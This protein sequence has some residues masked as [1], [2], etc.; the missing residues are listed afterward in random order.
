MALTY[1]PQKYRE[2][3]VRRAILIDMYSVQREMFSMFDRIT[4]RPNAP[5]FFQRGISTGQMTI[6]DLQLL[7]RNKRVEKQYEQYQVI[8]G[9][10]IN[11][12]PDLK[13]HRAKIELWVSH[14]LE[15]NVHLTIEELMLLKNIQKHFDDRHGYSELDEREDDG[16]FIPADPTLVVYHFAFFD[17]YQLYLQLQ[18][19]V[20]QAYKNEREVIVEECLNDIHLKNY[21]K[22]LLRITRNYK[23]LNDQSGFWKLYLALSYFKTQN[24]KKGKLQIEDWLKINPKPSLIFN[25]S[26][27]VELLP[28][29]WVKAKIDENFTPQEMKEFEALVEQE[30]ALRDEYIQV[31]QDIESFLAQRDA[32][33]AR[34][35]GIVPPA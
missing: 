20:F 30:V 15:L 17:L 9:V 18:R 3:R 25:R 4:S 12:L 26:V 28:I 31:C 14:I 13:K 2:K 1:L 22:A 7:L 11:V 35:V 32:E 19:I 21:S 34:R 27:L 5:S 8:N 33:F 10:L 24:E 6:A 29:S 23:L 16:R